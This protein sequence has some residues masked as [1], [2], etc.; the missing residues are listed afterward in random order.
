LD[1][2]DVE[3]KWEAGYR[4]PA[5]LGEVYI[6]REIGRLKR[7]VEKPKPKRSFLMRGAKQ[8][9]PDY[10]ELREEFRAFL[11]AIK[12]NADLYLWFALSALAERGLD[13]KLE[14][15]V[16][17]LFGDVAN[18]FLYIETNFDPSRVTTDLLKFLKERLTR[19]AS[20][21]AYDIQGYAGSVTQSGEGEK[22]FLESVT[23]LQKLMNEVR[24]DFSKYFKKD[25]ELEAASVEHLNR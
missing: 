8:T 14:S 7:L 5:G 3:K 20:P 16:Y 6:S 23:S 11:R 13:R 10:R 22:P 21:G 12:D 18:T 9:E 15:K 4:L 2:T 17:R 24:Y 25:E 19:I 1:E